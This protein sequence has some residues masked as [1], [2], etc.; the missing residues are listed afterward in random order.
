MKLRFSFW[1]VALLVLAV[2]AVRADPLR[3]RDGRTIQGDFV[4]G[5]PRQVRF[6]GKDGVLKVYSIT[7]IRSIVFGEAPAPTAR[8]PAA[9]RRSSIVLRPSQP[10][11]SRPP[12]ASAS[13]SALKAV[14]LPVG[15]VITVRM[16]DSIDSD[17]TQEG[18]KFLASLDDPLVVDE[19]IVVERGA[20]VTVQVVRVEQS[21]KF[22]GRDEVAL[23]L[24]DITIG[25]KKY[26]V[27]SNYAEVASGSRGERTAKV[28]GGTAALGAIIGAIA[29][30]GKGAAIGATAGAGAGAAVQAA[31]RGQ[32]VQIPSESR[33]DFTLTQ[34]LPVK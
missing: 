1:S 19:R 29:G 21:G 30:G 31:T 24:S 17:V 4:D 22:A 33:L 3:L 28:V 2:S 25:G 7:E 14:S 27:A 16:I 23:K 6:M 32:R 9:R 12:T 18:E 20:D 5:S 8:R 34:P 26:A 11:Q 15:T 13:P 10:T